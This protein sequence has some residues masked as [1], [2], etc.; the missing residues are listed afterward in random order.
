MHTFVI[1]REVYEKH[2]WV[3]RSLYQAFTEAQ[4]ITYEDLDDTG[5][6]QA[7]L[8]W[9]VS[10]VEDAK[11]EMGNDW[12]PYGIEPNRHVLE[13]FLRYHHEQGLS[14]QRLTPEDIFAP[15]TLE[16]FKV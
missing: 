8:P 13:T 16:S 2:R 11:R 15:E 7:M 10:H 4:R 3:A 1:R 5:T 9:L 6:L 12:W 14:K